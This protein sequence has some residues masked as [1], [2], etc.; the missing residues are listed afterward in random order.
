MVVFF[1]IIGVCLI[2]LGAFSLALAIVSAIYRRQDNTHF[3]NDE[4]LALVSLIL[5][6]V[7]FASVAMS[8]SHASVL[9]SQESQKQYKLY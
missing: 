3:G 7:S 9:S 6:L 2:L 4:I 5:G 8:I 1:T